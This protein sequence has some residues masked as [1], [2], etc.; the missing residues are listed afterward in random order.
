M[1]TALNMTAVSTVPFVDFY[2]RT[3]RSSLALATLLAGNREIAAELLQ[4][5]YLSAHRRWCTISRYDSPELWLRR[6]IVNQARSVGRR[7]KSERSAMQR[8][9]SRSAVSGS[10]EPSSAH[11]GDEIDDIWEQVR[12]LPRR[13][14]VAVTLIYGMDQSIAQ[15]AEV[16]KCSTGTV[17]THLSRARTRLSAELEDHR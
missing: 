17:K 4:E 2:E 10:S 12:A 11:S 9:E 7:R 6:V 14:A 8:L 13:Q 15:A 1:D 5:S 3:Y 16:M